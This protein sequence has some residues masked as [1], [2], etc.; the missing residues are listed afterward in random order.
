MWLK[1]LEKILKK[2]GDVR[3]ETKLVDIIIEDNQLKEVVLENNEGTYK[4]KV[5]QLVLAIGHSVRKTYEMLLSKTI[6]NLQKAFCSGNAVLNIVKNLL[7][8]TNMENFYDHPA[9]KRLIINWRCIQVKKRGVYTFC[10]CP[11]VMSR[12]ATSEEKRLKVVNR[13]S[14]YKSSD[15][16]YA[17][18]VSHVNSRHLMILVVSHPLVLGCIFKEN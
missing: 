2:W 4:E 10:M 17:N 11:V 7:I 13:M 5:D 1:I 18:S 8:K 16:K 14:N 9:L 12:N 6:R 3:F 15:N